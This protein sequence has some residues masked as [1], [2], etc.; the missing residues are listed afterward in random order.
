MQPKLVSAAIAALFAGSLCAQG[1]MSGPCFVSQLGTSLGL[2]DDQVAQAQALGF[3]FPG[4]AGPVT[5]IDISSNGFVWLGSSTNSACC[6]GNV[7]QFL[8]GL[9]R[10]AMQ[11]TD[12]YPPGNGDVWFNT[13]PAT[14]TS[15]ASAVITWAD[16]PEIGTSNLQTMQLQ[17]FDDGSFS[18]LFDGRVT[19]IGHDAL[20]GVTEGTAATANPIDFSATGIASPHNSLTNPTIYELF[21]STWD[22]ANRL[23]V[24]I[25]NGQ[26]GYLVLDRPGCV[27]ANVTTFG[28]GC[29]KPATAYEWFQFPSVIDLSNTAIE[30]TPAT[31]GGYVAVPVPG[32]FNGYT[33]GNAFGDDQV[34]GPFNLGFTFNYAGSSTTAID[35]SSNGFIWLQPGNTNPRCC[36]GDPTTFVSDP[37]SIAALWMDLYPPGGGSIYFDT[38]PGEAHITWLNVPEYFNGPA[39]TA[40]ITLRA[41][42]SFRIAYGTVNNTGHSPLVGFTQGIAGVDPGSSDFSAGPVIVGSG[43]TPLQ[44]DAQPASRPAI[45]TT[46]VME[47]DQIAPGS[48]IGIMVLGLNAVQPGFD[49]T[50]LGMPGCELLATLDA[51][52]TFPLAGSPAPFPF[53]IANDPALA[54]FT[55]HAQAATL[56]PGANPLGLYTSNGLSMLVGF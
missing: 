31:G 48:V 17:L 5:S 12:L 39:Q 20:I 4:P 34:Q 23:F 22:I 33:A 3:T 18:M 32:F 29:P 14:P 8:T 53:T 26:G 37:A 41:N 50:P 40:Q 27:L 2:G 52:L 16:V 19:N 1:A 42:G 47:V 24:F 15:P 7:T 54:G 38:T 13:F 44:L 49:L 51:L 30:F 28:V 56:T 10:I 6:N 11:W 35:I 43:G 36:D 55:L 45:G 9:P 21:Q 25:P 46:F